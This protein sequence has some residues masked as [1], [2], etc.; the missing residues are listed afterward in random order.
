MVTLLTGILHKFRATADESLVID[1]LGLVN[2][3]R[4]QDDVDTLSDLASQFVEKESRQYSTLSLV[5]D[6][7]DTL[8]Q[9]LKHQIWDYRAK[10]Y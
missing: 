9:S 7:Y 10:V 1:S 8:K 2:Q 6:R 3:L 4:I 5:F